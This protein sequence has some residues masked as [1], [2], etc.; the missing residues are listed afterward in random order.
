M[1]NNYFSSVGD[2]G[3]VIGAGESL[4]FDFTDEAASIERTINF[5]ELVY[6][7]DFKLRC[8]KAPKGTTLT[9]NVIDFDDNILYRPCNK[10]LLH[11]DM[12]IDLQTEKDGDYEEISPTE[13][14]QMII[15]SGNSSVDFQAIC[16]FHLLRENTI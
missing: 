6:V 5:K 7:H 15:K 3:G 10:L 1:L 2:A 11:G 14:I 8:F 16:H 9:I 12:E 13:K 4:F